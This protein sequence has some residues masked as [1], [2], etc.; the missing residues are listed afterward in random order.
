MGCCFSQNVHATTS[1]YGNKAV[2]RF[3]QGDETTTDSDEPEIVEDP[4]KK[5]E[6]LP[7]TGSKISL[8]SLMGII[9][10]WMSWKL[11]KIREI[12]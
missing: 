11:K 5:Q 6:K 9:I 3:Y 8:Y 4:P 7:Q 2:I 12:L 1:T 10:L